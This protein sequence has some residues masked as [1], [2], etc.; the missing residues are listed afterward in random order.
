V[1]ERKLKLHVSF[2]G[3][4]RMIEVDEGSNVE[5]L[6]RTL[7]LYVDAHIVMSLNRPLPLTNLLHD[8]QELKIIQ[9]ASGG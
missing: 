3:E 5:D 8:E 7:R 4:V 2:K 6:L 1:S 9:V